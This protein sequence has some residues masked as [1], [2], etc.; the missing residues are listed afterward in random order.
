MKGNDANKKKVV[1]LTPHVRNSPFGN[2]VV[3][4]KQT[5]KNREKNKKKKENSG[6]CNILR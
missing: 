4:N 5:K 3:I 1:K 6:Y 2:L